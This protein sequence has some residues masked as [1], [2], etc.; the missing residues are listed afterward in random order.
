M[1]GTLE[2]GSGFWNAL[3][4]TISTI[5]I[6][7]FIYIFRSLGVS[8]YKP[9]GDKAKPFLSGN[10]EINKSEMHF[11]GSNIYWGWFES[12]ENLFNK[13][14]TYHSGI[15]NDYV[16]WFIVVLAMLFIIFIVFMRFL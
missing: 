11:G 2:T 4:W 8:G 5:I 7:L 16:A 10:P 15:V 1:L 13:I 12:F 14:T 9:K 3:A 6:C